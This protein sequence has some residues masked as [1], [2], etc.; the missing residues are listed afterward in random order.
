MSLYGKC[1][2]PSNPF[3]SPFYSLLKWKKVKVYRAIVFH[4]V[5]VLG[6]FRVLRWGLP[7]RWEAGH[8]IF[9]RPT[10]T[11]DSTALNLGGS[12][13]HEA[14]KRWT[15]IAKIPLFI[16]IVILIWTM[17]INLYLLKCVKPYSFW[18]IFVY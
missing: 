11:I 14:H 17:Y 8:Q 5:K 9:V 4:W 16:N 15:L 6:R 3:L 10:T 1:T 12:C 13:L 18:R 2:Y 7:C